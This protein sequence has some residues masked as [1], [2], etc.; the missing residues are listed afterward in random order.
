[1][2]NRTRVSLCLFALALWPAARWSFARL[3]APQVA[4]AK[5][6]PSFSDPAISPD[7]KEI[8]FV[9]GGDIWSVPAEGGEARLLVSHPATESHPMYSPDGKKL[10]F[11]S[12]RTG[13]GDIYV[14]TFATGEL[15][16]LTFDDGLDLLNAWSRDARWIYFSSTSHDISGM[17]DIYRVSVEGGTPMPVSADR[18]ANEFFSAPSPDGNTL[19]FSAR[20]TASGQWWR[21]GHSHLD[22][23]E[24]WLRH[25]GTPA[26]YERVTE[27]GAKEMWPMWSADGRILYYISDRSGAENIWM[28]ALSGQGR[29]ITKFTSGRALWPNISYDGK[30]IVFERDFGIWKLDTASGQAA[31]VSIALRGAVPS[32]AVQHLTLSS[33]IS[34]LALSPDAKKIAFAVRGEIFAASAR[35][36]GDAT[37]VTRTPDAK[38]YGIVWSPDSKRIVYASERESPVRLFLYDFTTNEETQLTRGTADDAFP[39]FSP[40]GKLLAFFRGGHELRVLDLA[41]KQERILATGSLDA[42]PFGPD[43]PFAW[44]PDGRWIAYIAATHKLFR[45]I[46]VVPVAGGESKPVSFLPNVFGNGVNWSPDGTF[47]LYDSAQRTEPGQV[48]RID[49]I[50]RAPHF[51]EDQFRELF[52]DESP[53]GGGGAGAPGRPDQTKPAPKPVEIVFEGINRRASL[54]PRRRGRQF[55][56]HQPGRQVA[57]DDCGRGWPAEPLCLLAR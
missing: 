46:Q 1:M 15:K 38:E 42:P 45:N 24:V 37:R 35:D 29:Q 47:L 40:D 5:P 44:S 34:D 32:P 10:A 52:K 19:A 33:D 23:A 6:L 28:R 27:G 53:R 3:P 22:E 14:L 16:R 8:A 36:G 9:S 21:K 26:T 43:R 4:A 12:T 48:A 50:P 39:Q 18:Y 13:N 41:A 20:G 55:A 11:V 49:L 56:D 54:V 2:K 51:R 7:R 31:P 57:L 30:M 17:N 25:E